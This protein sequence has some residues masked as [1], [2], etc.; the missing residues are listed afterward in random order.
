[1]KKL[2]YFIAVIGIMSITTSCSNEAPK[3]ENETVKESVSD[4]YHFDQ[5][6]TLSGTVQLIPNVSNTEIVHFDS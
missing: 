3:T 2:I 5:A 4:L 1:M 6:N